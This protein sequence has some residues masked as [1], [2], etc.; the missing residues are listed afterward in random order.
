M[1][2]SAFIHV[3]SMYLVSLLFAQLVSM[4]LQHPSL[5]LVFLQFRIKKRIQSSIVTIMMDAFS[6]YLF[7]HELRQLESNSIYYTQLTYCQC[8]ADHGD[9]RCLQIKPSQ[10]VLMPNSM[11]Y[12]TTLQQSQ[13]SL[14]PSKSVWH[15]YELLNDE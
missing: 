6:E 2:S 4:W 5:E 3:C 10:P 7:K 12:E 11:I 14:L 13:I 15:N 1:M 8:I 9:Q